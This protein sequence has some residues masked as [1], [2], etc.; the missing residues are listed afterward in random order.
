MSLGAG[1]RTRK[2]VAMNKRLK[3]LL[4][5]LGITRCEINLPGCLINFALGF[6][7]SKKS[8]FIITN[9][10]WMEAALCCP[11]CHDKLDNRMSHEEME[12][13]VK[14]AIEKR[15]NHYSKRNVSNGKPMTLQP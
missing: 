13:L 11:M 5:G 10:D 1:K 9:D 3:K 7:H 2:R 15:S 6:A 4:E 12:R 8:R 14:S